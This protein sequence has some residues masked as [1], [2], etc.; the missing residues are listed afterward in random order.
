M[1]HGTN[2]A[3]RPGG[4]I[5][6]DRL[7]DA[8]QRL[9]LGVTD[10]DAPAR[11]LMVATVGRSGGAE[12]RMVVLRAVDPTAARLAFHT[13]AAS[14]KIAELALDPRISLIVWDQ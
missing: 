11:H 8:W 14:G 9:L 2:E 13:D 12:A 7:S 10:R 3:E 5:L 6:A 4:P 1:I